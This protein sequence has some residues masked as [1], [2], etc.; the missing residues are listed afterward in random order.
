MIQYRHLST[1]EFSLVFITNRAERYITQGSS[2][3]T[4]PCSVRSNAEPYRIDSFRTSSF[5]KSLG[6]LG[7]FSDPLGPLGGSLGLFLRLLHPI[8]PWMFAIR[9][10]KKQNIQHVGLLSEL[11]NDLGMSRFRW[12]V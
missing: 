10:K 9:L 12:I 5:W 7:C 1:A 3:T 6:L 2:K 8:H 11:P 4:T